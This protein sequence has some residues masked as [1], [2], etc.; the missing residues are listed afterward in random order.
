[1][2]IQT[3]EKLEPFNIT[4]WNETE[5]AFIKIPNG[6]DLLTVRDLF[7]VFY[8]KEQDE[9]KRFEAG[10]R[11]ACLLLLKE[12]G[13]PL[14]NLQDKDVIRKASFLPLLRLF[15]TINEVISEGLENGLK[16]S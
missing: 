5:K 8:D 16:K 6:F 15:S 11:A 2:E 9:E 13:S 10:F 1:M 12:D 4:E 7:L 14:L 3:T